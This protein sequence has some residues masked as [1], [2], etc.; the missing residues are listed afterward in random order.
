MDSMVNGFVPELIGDID[1]L[2]PRVHVDIEITNPDGA[3][4]GV[5]NGDFD[6]A[7]VANVAPHD[8]LKFH[9]LREFPLGCVATPEHPVASMERIS[10]SEFVAHPVV[11][12]SSA[13]SIRK[14]LEA[15]HGWIFD[16][17]ASS[18]TVNSIQLMKLLVLSGC[19]VA[20]TSEL[21]AGPE[22]RSE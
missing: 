18:V 7:A 8:N 19:Y 6:I 4:K 3:A 1:R 2:Y 11:F 14:L 22:I 12:Q 10:F 21:E 9:R 16:R 20:V 5:L 13:L 15:R 17:A